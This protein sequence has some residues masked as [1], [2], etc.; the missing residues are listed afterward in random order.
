M[1]WEPGSVTLNRTS[2]WHPRASPRI[3]AAGFGTPSMPSN[4]PPE[5]HHHTPDE[6]TSHREPPP[7]MQTDEGRRR[8][9]PRAIVAHE[10]HCCFCPSSRYVMAP[11]HGVEAH[12]ETPPQDGPAQPGTSPSGRGTKHCRSSPKTLGLS[13]RRPRH[14]T[15]QQR[16]KNKASTRQIMPSRISASLLRR[17]LDRGLLASRARPIWTG[18]R[19]P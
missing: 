2:R 3:V 1:L 4:S 10:M 17:A 18:S 11:I 12:V 6:Q 14:T 19:P 13:S 9:T 7:V 8:Q 5:D 15:T 16:A